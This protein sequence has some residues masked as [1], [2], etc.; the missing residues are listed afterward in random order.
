MFHLLQKCLANWK[1]NL[2]TDLK[3]NSVEKG[4]CCIG[5]QILTVL[6]NETS[7]FSPIIT[8]YN[9]PLGTEDLNK[10]ACPAGTYNN[11]TGTDSVFDCKS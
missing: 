5:N 7:P 4:D 6:G 3:K 11:V 10:F 9:C 1:Y 2:N 8:G